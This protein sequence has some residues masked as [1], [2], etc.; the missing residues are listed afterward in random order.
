MEKIVQRIERDVGI[1]GLSSI[2]AERINP[3]DLQSLLL[4]VH[5]V[6]A[7][8][9]APGEVLRDFEVNRFVRPS[10]V[11]VQFLLE[12]ERL[13]ISHLPKEFEALELSPL[14][15]LATNSAVAPVS[16]DWAIGTIR[17]TEVVSDPTNVLAL[18]AALR[19]RGLLR[20]PVGR[21]TTVHL[22]TRQRVVRGQR[23]SGK[24][25]SPHF[26]LLTLCSAGRDSGSSEFELSALAT[27]WVFYAAALKRFLGNDARLELTVTD[28]TDEDRSRQ[29]ES[30][31][32]NA[33]KS[34]NPDATMKFD[35]DRKKG[36]RYYSNICFKIHALIPPDQIIEIGDGGCVDWTSRL[37]SDSKERLV[38]S[39]IGSERVAGIK[40]HQTTHI[41]DNS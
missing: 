5:R 8:R 35:H 41:G 29:I 14:T 6:R 21:R 24:D 22:A 19:R 32:F 10:R 38:I 1:P 26:S 37:L 34:I 9:R 27:H 28:L 25:E 39:A 3:T 17:N 16:Q 15:P 36:M 11:A 12:W 2:L 7:A 30:Q 40:H 20:D 31:L 33:V 4:H 18:E 23:F 13:A